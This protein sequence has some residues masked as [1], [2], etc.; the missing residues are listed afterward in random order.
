MDMQNMYW[1]DFLSLI[2][3]DVQSSGL[4]FVYLRL[5]NRQDRQHLQ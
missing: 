5:Q 3:P 1:V 4:G 2:P